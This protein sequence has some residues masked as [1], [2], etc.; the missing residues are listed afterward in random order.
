MSESR[1]AQRVNILLRHYSLLPLSEAAFQSS[2]QFVI[3]FCALTAQQ[4]PVTILQ[5][6][7][8]PISLLNMA[9][10]FTRFD[11]LSHQGTTCIDV[12]GGKDKVLLFVGHLLLLNSRLLAIGFFAATYKWWVISVLLTHSCLITS[13]T[14]TNFYR[15]RNLH[16]V[17]GAEGLTCCFW[18]HNL[19]DDLSVRLHFL[20][21]VRNDIVEFRRMQLWCNYLF[22]AENVTMILLV[23]FS[24]F[25]NN[26]YSFG[27]VS[28]CECLFAVFGAIMRVTHFYFLTSEKINSSDTSGDNDSSSS[29]F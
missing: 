11:E 7:S 25:S 1:Y 20:N 27:P 12:M 3:Q 15:V 19:R 4:R 6:I 13:C 8:L 9:W 23:Y 10:A 2:P 17:K 24:E 28:V 18:L 26:W 29:S 5:M 22:V 16:R 14:T 21:T